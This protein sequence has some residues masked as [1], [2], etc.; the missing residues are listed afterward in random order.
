MSS[1]FS[2]MGFR[3]NSDNFYNDFTK[4][5]DDNVK[6][7][8][9]EVVLGNKKYLLVYVDNDIEFWLPISEEGFLD[10]YNFEIHYNTHRWEDIKNPTWVKKESDEMQGL[11]NIWQGLEE[12]FTMNVNIPNAI[13]CPA[14]KEDFIYKCQM[15]CFVDDIK[16]YSTVQEFRKEYDKINEE[17]FIP[18][19]M[20]SPTCEKDFLESANAWINGRIESFKLKTNTYTKNKY[21]HL[22]LSCYG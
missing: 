20:F 12:K 10:P 19:G 14:F 13:M 11:C 17:S 16:I 22:L 2:C 1:H 5:I 3:F 9:Q 8:A 7:S 21:Y 6:K 18:T 15:V 4:M